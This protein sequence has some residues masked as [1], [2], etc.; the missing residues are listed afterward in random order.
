MPRIDRPGSAGE[1]DVCKER[2]ET[3]SSLRLDRLAHGKPVVHPKSMI[4][5]LP[6]HIEAEKF[7]SYAAELRDFSSDHGIPFGTPEALLVMTNH[8]KAGD[9]FRS[10]CASMMRSVVYR[11]AGEAPPSELLTLAAVAWGGDTVFACVHDLQN[12]IEPLYN[13]LRSVMRDTEPAFPAETPTKL[14][15]V[16]TYPSHGEAD[17]KRK[18]FECRS[19]QDIYTRA[20][21]INHS[22]ETQKVEEGIE[23]SVSDIEAEIGL[24]RA[25][26]SDVQ[27]YLLLLDQ[28]KEAMPVSEISEKLELHEQV[29]DELTRNAMSPGE[30]NL[31]V[32]PSMYE[33]AGVRED[34]WDENSTLQRELR[35]FAER[36]RFREAEIQVQRRVQRPRGKSSIARML[37]N[38]L[39][40]NR[41]R[42]S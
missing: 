23:R 9:S 10:E 34:P 32:I 13:F 25:T 35:L 26:S 15:D 2:H 12:E 1:W 42:R 30:P 33:D 38:V 7:E 24:L 36:N 28:R 11:E 3:R 4:A 41:A 20:A 29:Q 18:N 39:H 16:L 40:A 37:S 27:L 19:P 14:A 8:L 6:T 31:T 22:Q 21:E 17:L 5:I